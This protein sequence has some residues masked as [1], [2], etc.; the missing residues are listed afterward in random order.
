ML[1]G[2]KKIAARIPSPQQTKPQ[3]AVQVAAT[4]TVVDALTEQKVWCLMPPYSPQ[5]AF[6]SPWGFGHCIELGGVV[7]FISGTEDA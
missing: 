6:I 3:A 1:D 2:L 4:G 7:T 5:H